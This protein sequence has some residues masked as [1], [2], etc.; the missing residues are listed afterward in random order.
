MIKISHKINAIM[1]QYFKKEDFIEMLVHCVESMVIIPRFELISTLDVLSEFMIEKNRLNDEFKRKTNNVKKQA[2]TWI[3]SDGNKNF[4]KIWNSDLKEV[5]EKIQQMYIDSFNNDVSELIEK[6]VRDIE[7]FADRIE[8]RQKKHLRKWLLQTGKE[9]EKTQED[10]EIVHLKE[11]EAAKQMDERRE[12]DKK[13]VGGKTFKER[14][15]EV[16]EAAKP[17][18]ME[19]KKMEKIRKITDL[20]YINSIQEIKKGDNE[21][22]GK[23]FYAFEKKLGEKIGEEKRAMIMKLWY[24]DYFAKEQPDSDDILNIVKRYSLHFKIS[25]DHINGEVNRLI[26]QTYIVGLYMGVSIFNIY[27]IINHVV[28][29]SPTMTAHPVMPSMIHDSN[30]PNLKVQEVLNPIITNLALQEDQNIIRTNWNKMRFPNI[31]ISALVEE[32]RSVGM[33]GTL[34]FKIISL[35][36]ELSDGIIKKGLTI[37]RFAREVYQILKKQTAKIP[38]TEKHIVNLLTYE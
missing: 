29:L 17:R 19:S 8:D 11:L 16:E 20:K 24:G 28:E 15:K 35:I 23:I 27:T 22:F 10:L 6:Y 33:D 18:P 7:D 34:E 9:F 32:I 31:D 21:R 25:N 12:H 13:Y 30:V 3:L 4:S 26:L 14:Q 38:I 5:P 2:E 37:E 36:E 1:L